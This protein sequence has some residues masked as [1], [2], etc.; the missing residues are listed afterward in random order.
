VGLIL[1]VMTFRVHAMFCRELP[2]G[3]LAGQPANRSKMTCRKP[4]QSF[5][6]E[7][8]YLAKV[9]VEGSNPFARSN[10]A[11]SHSLLQARI[12][13]SFCGRPGEASGWGSSSLTE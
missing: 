1:H 2:F 11:L 7:G 4:R 8:I 5:A 3:V 12:A 10:N 9:G 13:G 6:S